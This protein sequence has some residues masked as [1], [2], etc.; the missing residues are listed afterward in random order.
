MQVKDFELELINNYK[1]TTPDYGTHA[2]DKIIK[3]YASR[4]SKSTDPE[5]IQGI[6]NTSTRVKKGIFTKLDK[7]LTDDVLINKLPT[8]WEQVKAVRKDTKEVLRKKI[9]GNMIGY[10][11]RDTMKKYNDNRNTV[12]Q[13]RNNDDVIK[14]NIEDTIQKAYEIIELPTKYYNFFDLFIVTL[15]MCGRRSHELHEK[16]IFMQSSNDKYKIE[17]KG[18][19]KTSNTDEVV[20]IPLLC[21]SDLFIKCVTTLRSDKNYQKRTVNSFQ[22]QLQK[23]CNSIFPFVETVH[24]LRAV[25][26][27]T[28]ERIYNTQ[29]YSGQELKP[30]QF[31]KKVL[32]HTSIT[33][34]FNHYTSYEANDL[35]SDSAVRTFL[36]KFENMN[37]DMLQTNDKFIPLK[38]VNLDPVHNKQKI[39][40]RYITNLL[41]MFKQPRKIS[42]KEYNQKYGGLETFFNEIVEVNQD[43]ISEHN[44]N[45]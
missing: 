27:E 39:S 26:A 1:V 4:Q 3:F 36:K 13:K 32:H 18:F 19:A 9:L 34:S 24:Q 11:L 22:K 23:H 44:N 14:F 29:Y 37:D 41:K 30:L 40:E 16:M 31:K 15:L 35:N 43:I 45:V 6:I 33:T 12:I 10:D 21:S 28:C 8:R 20:T 7:V 25:Y 17:C 5:N 2:V 42:W 38:D